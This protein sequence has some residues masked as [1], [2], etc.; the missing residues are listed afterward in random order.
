MYYRTYPYIQLKIPLMLHFVVFKVTSVVIK[1]LSISLRVTILSSVKAFL[2][3]LEN[4]RRSQLLVNCQDDKL[5]HYGRV[6]PCVIS[7]YTVKIS[8]L[9]CHK[10]HNL[11]ISNFILHADCKTTVY[12]LYLLS[13]EIQY[14][15][16]T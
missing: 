10:W 12:L 8:R 14:K 13:R 9:R 6:Q 15:G 16:E 3:K 7:F 11:C 5:D 1:I 4:W 2:L